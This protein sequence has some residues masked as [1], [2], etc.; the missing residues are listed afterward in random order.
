MEEIIDLTPKQTLYEEPEKQEKQENILIDLDPNQKVDEEPEKQENILIDLDPKQN[1][2]YEE[3]GNQ[4]NILKGSPLHEEINKFEPTIE[5]KEV[6]DIIEVENKSTDPDLEFKKIVILYTLTVLVI[7]GAIGG[8]IG[9][10]ITYRVM[11]K[12]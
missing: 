8:A 10:G 3:P 9:F 4:E 5:H 7:G 11:K 2:L 12:N 1:S 6:K